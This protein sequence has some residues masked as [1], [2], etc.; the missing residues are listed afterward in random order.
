MDSRHVLEKLQ[1]TNA[2]AEIWWDS[3]PMVYE[4]WARKV[5]ESPSGEERAL[6]GTAAEAF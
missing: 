4:N 5:S 3:A 1:A 2:N 6:A